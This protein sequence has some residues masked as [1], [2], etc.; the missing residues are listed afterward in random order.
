[1]SDPLPAAVGLTVLDVVEDEKLVE[2][3]RHLGKQLFDGL[4]ALMQRYDCVGDIRGRGM[5][6]GLEIVTDRRSRNPD[7][8][9]GARIAEEALRRGLNMNIVKLPGMGGVFRLAPPLTIS[10]DELELGIG[11]ISASI[12]AVVAGP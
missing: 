4:D 9:T 10:E 5:M 12:G 1:V 6:A 11:I 3:A 8:E 2:R 7:H